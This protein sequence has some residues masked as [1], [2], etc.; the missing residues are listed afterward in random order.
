[1]RIFCDD[2]GRNELLDIERLV[3]RDGAGRIGY[4]LQSAFRLFEYPRVA[5]GRRG[6]D[7]S[8]GQLRSYQTSFRPLS[9]ITSDFTIRAWSATARSKIS[10]V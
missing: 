7:F 3:E 6:P 1:M 10:S 2:C 4:E 5:A 9:V 8:G